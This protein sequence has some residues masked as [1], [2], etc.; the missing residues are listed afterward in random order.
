ME[1]LCVLIYDNIAYYSKLRDSCVEFYSMKKKA[2]EL[3]DEEC[4]RLDAG[5]PDADK[6]VQ[7]MIDAAY[8]RLT[9]EMR[10]LNSTAEQQRAAYAK[11]RQEL[12]T[13]FAKK[14]EALDAKHRQ[15]IQQEN[16]RFQNEGQARDE[17][18]KRNLMDA[19]KQYQDDMLRSFPP[20]MAGRKCRSIQRSNEKN[21]L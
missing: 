18:R 10:N 15:Q 9:Q 11:Y 1:R 17:R 12:I 13:D 8:Q 19:L 5:I 4:A 21:K 20:G 2:K 14:K 3:Y 6:K 7:G 16:T